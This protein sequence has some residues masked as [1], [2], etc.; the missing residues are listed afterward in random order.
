MTVVI[1]CF[2]ALAANMT[3]KVCCEISEFS[4]NNEIYNL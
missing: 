2:N 4:L 1:N 3:G